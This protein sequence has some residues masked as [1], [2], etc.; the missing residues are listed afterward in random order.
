MNHESRSVMK[1]S[2]NCKLMCKGCVIYQHLRKY[3][4]HSDPPKC[5]EVIL[6]TESK[7]GT[8]SEQSYTG[9][10]MAISGKFC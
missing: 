10:C 6:K 5:A 4:D 1:R 7:C 8:C 3:V 2:C 9:T